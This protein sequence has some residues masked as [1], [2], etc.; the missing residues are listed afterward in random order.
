M[1]N[2]TPKKVRGAGIREGLRKSLGELEIELD[3]KLLGGLFVTIDRNGLESVLVLLDAVKD[4]IDCEQHLA[5]ID[6]VPLRVEDDHL[7][8]KRVNDL[9]LFVE[10]FPV[11]LLFGNGHLVDVH[12]NSKLL[13][14][15]AYTR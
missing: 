3:L 5:G 4:L 15:R 9:A 7:S 10:C 14:R 12:G 13:V 1:L 8:A 6:R 11:D 2:H